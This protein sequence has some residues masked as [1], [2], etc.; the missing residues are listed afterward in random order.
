MKLEDLKLLEGFFSRQLEILERLYGDVAELDLAKY[1]NLYVFALKA[2]QFYTALED[3]FK[4]IARVFENRVEDPTRFHRELLV[5]MNTEVPEI[6]MAVIDE[7]AFRFL[8]RL[9]RFRHFIR[10]AYDYELDR[11]EIEKLQKMFREDFEVLREDLNRFLEFVK[12]LSYEER[13]I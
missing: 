13:E 5:R 8:D 7:R 1:E 6:R 12:D 10:H 4:E 3:L 11:E 9:R 2:Q